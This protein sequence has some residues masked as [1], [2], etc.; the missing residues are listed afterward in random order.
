MKDLGFFGTDDGLPLLWGGKGGGTPKYGFELATNLNF[1][2]AMALA[3]KVITFY[4]ENGKTPERLGATIERVGVETFKKQSY[5][6]SFFAKLHPLSISAL[7]SAGG[8]W[9]IHEV[10]STS[11]P[12][13]A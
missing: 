7:T 4:K 9:Y 2:Q 13:F 1:D 3:D 11:A 8:A 6:P 10:T 12:A 5:N